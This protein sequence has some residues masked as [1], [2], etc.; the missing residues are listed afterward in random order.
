M[1]KKYQNTQSIFFIFKEIM[2]H[3]VAATLRRFAHHTGLRN[4]EDSNQIA[5]KYLAAHMR[6]VHPAIVYPYVGADYELVNKRTHSPPFS[7]YHSEL[8]I[9]PDTYV[10]LMQHGYENRPLTEEEAHEKYPALQHF[11]E[12]ML[13]RPVGE[14]AWV[15]FERKDHWKARAYFMGL[16]WKDTAGFSNLMRNIYGI[17]SK[18]KAKQSEND[19]FN[20]FLNA[21]YE[22]TPY[23]DF[24]AEEIGHILQTLNVGESL[25]LVEQDMADAVAVEEETLGDAD[26]LTHGN[27]PEKAPIVFVAETPKDAWKDIQNDEMVKSY[28]ERAG[29]T[30]FFSP[31]KAV[32]QMILSSLHLPIKA[33]PGAERIIPMSKSIDDPLP[34]V[35]KEAWPMLVN[36][37]ES[38]NAENHCLNPD[39]PILKEI[40]SGGEASVQSTI[41]TVLSL[42][43]PDLEFE[44]FDPRLQVQL[45][46]RHPHIDASVLESILNM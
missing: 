37:I 41:Q 46:K 10:Y 26:A 4:L 17:E 3:T 44:G 31:K 30:A 45:L 25:N 12:T 33:V 39:S 34:P 40:L 7:A 38:L 24:R 19:A 18:E 35:P 16:N 14:E 22:Y 13:P 42:Y 8:E 21:M 43:N 36:A 29:L 2:D 11:I 28:L 1:V 9:N 5:R 32:K 23:E 20:A 15:N 27:I 6:I